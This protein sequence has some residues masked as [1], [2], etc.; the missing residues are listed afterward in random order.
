MFRCA[1]LSAN[2]STGELWRPLDSDTSRINAAERYSRLDIVSHHNLH[3][4]VMEVEML[5]TG[6]WDMARQLEGRRTLSGAVA[7]VERREMRPYLSE[8]KTPTLPKRTPRGP[9]GQQD[10]SHLNFG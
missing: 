1:L 6:E 4:M 8:F 7:S 3:S 5:I 10:V 2:E 9:N